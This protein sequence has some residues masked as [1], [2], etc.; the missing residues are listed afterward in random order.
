MGMTSHNRGKGK[1]TR[2]VPWPKAWYL[3]ESCPSRIADSGPA[4]LLAAEDDAMPELIAE[5]LPT[6]SED[7]LGMLRV[8]SLEDIVDRV[9]RE[10][11]LVVLVD[12]RH[13]GLQELGIVAALHRRL[14]DVPVIG[15]VDRHDQRLA[16]QACQPG[17]VDL[18]VSPPLSPEKLSR[19]VD[20]VLQQRQVQKDRSNEH[21]GG[22]HPASLNEA[23]QPG[24][25]PVRLDGSGLQ[26]V[27]HAEEETT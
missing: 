27:S 5:T 8:T 3:I 6:S 26:S 14:P 25:D 17:R 12:L 2:T 1:R 13:Q 9:S 24:K 23:W 15:V 11:L 21:L 18:L 16:R 4:V 20:C 10:K 22:Y 7:D 19:A